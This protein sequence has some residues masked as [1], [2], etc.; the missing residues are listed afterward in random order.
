MENPSLTMSKDN[1]S[2]K[3]KLQIASRLLGCSE[4]T[5][6]IVD[7]MEIAGYSTPE[8]QGGQYKRE[9]FVQGNQYLRK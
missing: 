7:V 5:M 6:K 9:F 8:Q 4:G 1:G 2:P 3:R